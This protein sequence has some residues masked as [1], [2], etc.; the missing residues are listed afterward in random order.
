MK[1]YLNKVDIF[2]QKPTKE[3]LE[4]I[5]YNINKLKEIP[6]KTKKKK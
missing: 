6:T 3:V 4:S 5:W 2:C 1:I